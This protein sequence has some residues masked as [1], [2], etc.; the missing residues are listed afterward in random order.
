MWSDVVYNASGRIA[1]WGPKGFAK[2]Q[3]NNECTSLIFFNSI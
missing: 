1:I 3:E 2:S